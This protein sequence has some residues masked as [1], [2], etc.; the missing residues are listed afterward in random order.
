MVGCMTLPST[1]VPH[2]HSSQMALSTHVHI[3]LHSTTWMARG[4]GDLPSCIGWLFCDHSFS[5][6]NHNCLLF[7]LKPSFLLISTS[8]WMLG[9]DPFGMCSIIPTSVTSS[10]FSFQWLM[11]WVLQFCEVSMEWFLLI[12]IC[13]CNIT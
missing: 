10:F 8:S 4:P 13:L 7:F 11:V 12:D 3:L 1:C 5:L 9:Y 6:S 2:C